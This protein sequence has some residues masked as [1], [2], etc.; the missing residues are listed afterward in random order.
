MDQGRLPENF[1]LYLEGESWK[2]RLCEDA[3]AAPG[4]ETAHLPEEMRIGPA[5]GPR[6]LTEKDAQRI[7][8]NILLTLLQEKT[9]EQLSKMTIAEFV[10]HKFVPEHV[11]KKG[12]SGRAHY[13][14]ML[15]H[16]LTPEE[17]DRVFR[18]TA[19]ESRKGLKAVPDWPYLSNL[20]LCDARP[21]HIH[22]LTSAALAQGYST[23]TVIRI[24]TVVSAIFSHAKHQQ[25][26]LG[27]NPASP[28]RP[29]EFAR[30]NAEALSFAQAKEALGMMR[31]PEKEIAL[32]G[33]FTGM[34]VSEICGLQWKQ[35][36]LTG[37]QLTRDGEQIPP[38]TIA[39]RK[40]WYRGEFDS[41]KKSRIRN[42]A[43][44]QP[45]HQI[46]IKLKER[47]S[48]TG[49]DDFVLVSRAGR[50][51]NETNI[52]SRRLKPLG[53]QLG[54]PSLSWQVFRRTRRAL[55]VEFGKQFNDSLA[56][57]VRSAFPQDATAR[58]EWH[59][60]PQLRRNPSEY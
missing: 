60:R 25:C 59:C 3:P 19:E 17:V 15:K 11:V 20:R 30:K 10:E 42:L 52:V 1:K 54:V 2:M 50:P 28:V 13:Q 5:T 4:Y 22:Q 40:Q 26:F 53:E 6:G 46:L 9:Q 55:A 44:P 48:F 33:V 16:V 49:P 56:L 29:L 18:V 45:L 14:A 27:E 12:L 51:V 7:A 8:S 38:R 58:Y 21:D 37:T 24:R 41:V 31:Y 43:I 39:V 47:A 34:N 23:E 57:M 32:I 35:I 36:N